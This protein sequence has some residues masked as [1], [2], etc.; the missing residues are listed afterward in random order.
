MSASEASGARPTAVADPCD[1]R[2]ALSA[3]VA[4]ALHFD[5]TEEAAAL[6]ILPAV[7]PG[8]LPEKMLPDDVPHVPSADRHGDPPRGAWSLEEG[9]VRPCEDQ[10]LSGKHGGLLKGTQI[11]SA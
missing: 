4:R 10:D 5:R 11:P 7:R 8:A 2:Q 6:D 3:G 1:E 9:A